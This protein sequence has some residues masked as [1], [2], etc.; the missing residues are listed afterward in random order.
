[1]CLQHFFGVRN[2]ELLPNVGC[3]PIGSMEEERGKHPTCGMREVCANVLILQVEC[4]DDSVSD[5]HR[6]Q[7]C[8]LSLQIWITFIRLV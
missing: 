5:E 4:N 7:Y 3:T 2:N 8:S 1:M 6:T